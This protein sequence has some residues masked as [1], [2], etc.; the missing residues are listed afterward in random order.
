MD[1][2]IPA[3]HLKQAA[4][5]AGPACPRHSDN[6][7]FF[8]HYPALSCDRNVGVKAKRVYAGI[9]P[10]GQKGYL[11][12]GSAKKRYLASVPPQTCGIETGF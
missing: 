5:I 7:L 12:F 1:C 4:G 2:C 6:I 3:Q 8:H 10:A 9:G 11:H